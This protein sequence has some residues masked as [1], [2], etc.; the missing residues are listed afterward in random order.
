[1]LLK[2]CFFYGLHTQTHT[3]KHTHT[4]THTQ[5]H[6][7]IL[8]R[9]RTHIYIYIYIYIYFDRSHTNGLINTL[10]HAH[11]QAYTHTHTHTHTYTHTRTHTHTHAHTHTHLY[12]DRSHTNGLTHTHTHSHMHIHISHI[13]TELFQIEPYVMIQNYSGAPVSGFPRYHGYL[14]DVLDHLGAAVHFRYMLHPAPDGEFGFMTS[15]GTNRWT[16]MVGQL[17]EKVS[18]T[19]T[20]WHRAEI[21]IDYTPLRELLSA[22]KGASGNSVLNE[23]NL[24]ALLDVCKRQFLWWA[25]LQSQRIGIVRNTRAC[26]LRE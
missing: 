11:T 18:D 2:L 7:E 12:F 3:H 25:R 20:D 24:L 8:T 21:Y 19:Y 4:N 23:R 9:A 1:M 15:D 10:T 13:N 5:T 16:G 14:V 26:V 22:G 17:L 6:T